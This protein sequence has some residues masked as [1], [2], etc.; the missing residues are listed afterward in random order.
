MTCHEAS[1]ERSLELIRAVTIDD[2]S[3]S[4]PTSTLAYLGGLALSFVL[5]TKNS[6][7]SGTKYEKKCSINIQHCPSCDAAYGVPIN[8]FHAKCESELGGCGT[9]FCFLCAAVRSPILAHGNMMHRRSCP[10]NID[11]YCCNQGCLKDGKDRCVELQWSQHCTECQKNNEGEVCSFPSDINEPTS[12][13]HWKILNLTE[14]QR[15]IEIIKQK[16]SP[17]QERS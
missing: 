4:L 16:M 12:G 17:T 1:I 14:V 7:Y 13:K 5:G 8:C 9:E 2:T 6:N 10:Y 15:E 3:N 11:Q